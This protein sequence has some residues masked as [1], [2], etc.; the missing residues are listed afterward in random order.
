[1]NDLESQL[2]DVHLPAVPD[3]WPLSVFGYGFILFV[4][5]VL[6][7]SGLYLMKKWLRGRARRKALKQINIYKNTPRVNNTKTIANL[8]I[9]LRR[10]ALAYYPRHEV[11]GLTGAAW[12]EFLDKTGETEIFTKE[13]GDLLLYAPYQKK[14]DAD[15]SELLNT[16]ELWIQQRK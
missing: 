10:V 12:L 7:C 6:I 15:Y 13:I 5:V 11:A 9:L 8:S 1:M 16:I 3:W 14:A 4:L 2:K